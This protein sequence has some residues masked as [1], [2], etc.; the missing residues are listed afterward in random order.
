MPKWTK[1]A[2]LKEIEDLIREADQVAPHG[3]YSAAHVRW[4]LRT[5]RFLGEVFGHKSVYLRS[6]ATLPW[7]ATGSFI[8]Q[9]FDIQG[10]VEEHHFKAFIQQIDTAKGFLQAAWDELSAS[11]LDDVYHGKDTA[12][13][14]SAILKVINL[15]EHRLRK[16][17]RKPPTKEVVVQ[18]ALE[19]LFIG[20]DISYSREAETIEY[21]S[22]TYRPDFTIKQLDLAIDV[23]LCARDGREKEIIAEINDDILAYQT[24][25]GNILFVIYDV[26]QIRDSDRFTASFEEHENVM[27]RV[28]KH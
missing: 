15:A 13:E 4:D 18:E 25:Y 17:I 14:S 19:N 11:S 3:P 10:A 6:F 21:S 28:V 2:A 9:A 8:V 7:R 23:K 1:E 27:V 20:A 26:G 24:K 22:K 12:P 5:R 16:V